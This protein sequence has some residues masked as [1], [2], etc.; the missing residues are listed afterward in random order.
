MTKTASDRRSSIE[1]KNPPYFVTKFIFRATDP[2]KASN[3]PA[4]K[5]KTGIVQFHNGFERRRNQMK[6]AGGRVKKNPIIEILLG[7]M[8]CR[9]KKSTG[10]LESFS[11]KARNR[12]RTNVKAPYRYVGNII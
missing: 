12:L 2:S 1:S 3:A 5:I 8:L 9:T 6:N 10:P 4:I 7:V 11:P